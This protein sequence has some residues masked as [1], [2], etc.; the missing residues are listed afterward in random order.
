M[1][2]VTCQAG[3]GAALGHNFHLLGDDQA[4]TVHTQLER[5]AL[6]H[7]GAGRLKIFQ[8]VIDQAHRALGVQRQQASHQLVVVFHNLAAKAAAGCSLNYAH[9][10]DW[11]AQRHG[12]LHAHQVHRLGRCLQ[13]QA[14]IRVQRG[15]AGHGLHVP[16]ILGVGGVRGFV[17]Q[18]GRG[19]ACIHIAA[20]KL[21]M[22]GDVVA[23]RVDAK[24]LLIHGLIGGHD[25][26]QLFIFHANQIERIAGNLIGDGRH[27]CHFFTAKTHDTLGQN[28]AL[29]V[30]HAPEVG[31]R[32]GTR[33]HGFDTWQGFGSRGINADN[34]RMRVRAAQ[35]LAV[36]HARDLDVAGIHGPAQDLG[37]GRDLRG[38]SAQ[39]GRC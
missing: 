10:R 19:K 35:N 27:G 17:N 20:F 39:S 29:L 4:I 31:R 2:H 13:H 9:A 33:Q 32:I 5:D 18:V 15:D 1:H 28:R 24:G 25:G 38:V 8:P 22:V 37:L 3:I 26:R 21:N 12:N 11:Q 36:Q 34:A 6:G 14:A 30:V 16:R 23:L 7:A